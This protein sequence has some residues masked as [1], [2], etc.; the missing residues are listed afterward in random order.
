MRAPITHH[1]NDH[2]YYNQSWC[3][4]HD[5]END[6][7]TKETTQYTYNP[8]TAKLGCYNSDGS[9]DVI[10][11]DKDDIISLINLKYDTEDKEYVLKSSKLEK[12]YKN[13]YNEDD[14]DKF[15]ARANILQNQILYFTD[16]PEI[17]LI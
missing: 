10:E 2:H 4:A 7:I 6:Y 8:E 14:V 13:D 15:L 3:W 9:E 16:L 17:K 1:F 12:D 5:I 11:E